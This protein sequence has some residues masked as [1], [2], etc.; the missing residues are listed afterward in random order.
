MTLI[1]IR[2][3]EPVINEELSPNLWDISEEGR[4]EAERLVNKIQLIQ[5]IDL[6]YSSTE[7]KAISTAQVCVC[8]CV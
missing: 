2:H 7:K 8:V 4:L 5:K 1:F 6:I 3:A